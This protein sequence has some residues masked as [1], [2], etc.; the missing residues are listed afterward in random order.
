MSSLRFLLSVLVLLLLTIG[1]LGS[2]YFAFNGKASEWAKMV[3]TPAVV[4][5]SL[6]LLL[7]SII[8]CFV[9]DKEGESK[10]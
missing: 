7:A 3:D 1:Y 10:R 2:Q 6:L 4:Y 9:P 8:L 5:L